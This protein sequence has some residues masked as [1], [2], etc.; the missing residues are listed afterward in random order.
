MYRSFLFYLGEV[1]I[2]WEGLKSFS[3]LPLFI[4]HYSVTSKYKSENGQIFVAFSEYL[5]FSNTYIMTISH[6]IW[7]FPIHDWKFNNHDLLSLPN[8]I[9][10]P[11]DP[12]GVSKVQNW[13]SSR[14]YDIVKI[15]T[16]P[17]LLLYR[18]RCFVMSCMVCTLLDSLCHCISVSKQWTMW[19]NGQRGQI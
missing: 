5:N 18:I 11:N 4:G 12:M 9:I 3:H 8:T 16:N 7:L 14:C 2:F 13:A 15:D 6:N 19:T 1:H 17:S 10:Y